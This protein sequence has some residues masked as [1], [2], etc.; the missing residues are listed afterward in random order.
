MPRS[1]KLQEQWTLLERQEYQRA[2]E[3]AFAMRHELQGAALHDAYELMG[4]ACYRQQQYH[5]ASRWF[6]KACQGSDDA[7]DWYNL[8][9]SATMQGNVTLGAEAFEQVRICQQAARYQQEPGIHQQLYWYGCALCDTAQHGALQRVLDELATLYRRLHCTD[10]SFLYI[11]R[12]P[13]LSCFLT[14][15][16]RCFCE[17]ERY[18]EGE[19][20]MR[21]LSEGLDEDGQQQVTEAMRELRRAR[22]RERTLDLKHQSPKGRSPSSSIGGQRAKGKGR[23]FN[24]KQQ[25]SN[26]KG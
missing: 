8:A 22:M 3:G 21:A 6:K 5:H 17:Q 19:T 18:A 23:A 25:I 10:T 2:F 24:S 20:W 12:V 15:A 9:A 14:L 16:T 26:S 7:T 13:F 11:R 1:P 4:L